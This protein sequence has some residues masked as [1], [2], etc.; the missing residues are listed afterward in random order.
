M[1]HRATQMP[2]KGGTHLKNYLEEGRVKE[3]D[4]GPAL[5]RPTDKKKNV[6]TKEYK[7]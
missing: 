7:V 3:E 1:G 5:R 6:K 4:R 2:P